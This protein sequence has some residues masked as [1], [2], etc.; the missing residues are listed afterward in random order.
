VQTPGRI[1]RRIYDETRFGQSL[2]Q[3]R[4]GDWLIDENKSFVGRTIGF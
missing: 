1:G 4:C 2:N 3:W